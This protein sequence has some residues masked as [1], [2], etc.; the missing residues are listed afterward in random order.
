MKRFADVY[1]H[2]VERGSTIMCLLACYSRSSR[3][4][5]SAINFVKS[6]KLDIESKTNDRSF[7]RE[8]QTISFAFE[9]QR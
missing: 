8:L 6:L 4:F 3:L 2:I 5:R 1:A 7:V 9:P